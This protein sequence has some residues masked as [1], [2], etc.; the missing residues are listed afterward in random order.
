MAS[1]GGTGS[2]RR[3]DQLKAAASIH[4]KIGQIQRYCEL[5]VEVGE[6]ELNNELYKLMN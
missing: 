2:H 3:N 4:M 1:F 6:V 5:M